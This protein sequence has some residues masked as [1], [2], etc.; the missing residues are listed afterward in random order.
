MESTGGFSLV[1]KK[2][3]IYA[4]IFLHDG[5]QKQQHPGQEQPQTPNPKPQTP[6]PKPQ[7]PNPKPQKHL[8]IS[9]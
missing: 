2:V 1:V 3:T 8:L 4:I 6:N 5:K 7:T 9:I